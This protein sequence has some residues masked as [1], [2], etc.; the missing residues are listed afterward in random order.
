MGNKLFSPGDLA[1]L[2]M[3]NATFF[4]YLKLC[5]SYICLMSFVLQCDMREPNRLRVAPVPLYNTF[6]D[7]FKFVQILGESLDASLKKSKLQ[8]TDKENLHWSYIT[9]SSSLCK[10]LGHLCTCYNVS[11]ANIFFCLFCAISVSLVRFQRH[12]RK[13]EEISPKWKENMFSVK[14]F[15]Y[16]PETNVKF[17]ITCVQRQWSPGQREWLNLPSRGT[18]TLHSSVIIIIIIIWFITCYIF[19]I[20]HSDLSCPFMVKDQIKWT[21]KYPN[22]E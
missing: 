2:R 1:F 3:R 22:F 21:S 19:T 13:L 11:K 10:C 14:D 20:V 16:F 15:P 5:I 9:F 4:S 7:V 8:E 6:Y 18:D 12:S 17:Y